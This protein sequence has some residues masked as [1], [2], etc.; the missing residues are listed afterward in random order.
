ML[1]KREGKG[2]PDGGN[3]WVNGMEVGRLIAEVGVEGRVL[4]QVPSPCMANLGC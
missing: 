4:N 3:G 2:V 1:A